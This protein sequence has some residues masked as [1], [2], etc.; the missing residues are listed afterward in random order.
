M[1]IQISGQVGPQTLADGTGLQPVRQG[2]FG[3]TVVQD[4]HGRYYEQSYRGNTFF[5][6]SQAV[7]TTTVGLATTYTGLCISNPVGSGINMGILQASLMQSVIQATQIEAYAIATGFNAATN[8]THTT[9]LV[10]HPCLVGSGKNSS[11]LAD[12]S[13]T[14]PTAPFYTLFLT[15]TATAT[16]NALGVTVDLNSSIVLSPGG[17]ALFVTPGQASVAGL[18]FG[19]V[20]EEVPL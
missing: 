19:F 16:Q 15:N 9:P 7:A 8:V 12:T 17:Y 2:H 3:E 18:W 4:L 6:A 1:P 14:L 13:A 20:W 5:A 11:G 10:T